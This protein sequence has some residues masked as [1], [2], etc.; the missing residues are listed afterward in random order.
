MP[1]LAP[2]VLASV[3]APPFTP[4]VQPSRPN[5]AESLLIG[6]A[7]LLGL[8]VVLQRNGALAALFASAGQASAYASLE[9]SLGGPSF[10]TPRFVDVL[11]ARTP[12][13]PRK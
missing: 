3:A 12:A 10:G 7:A 11:V 4:S 2:P 6:L 1:S 5:R 13:P 8:V 9:T